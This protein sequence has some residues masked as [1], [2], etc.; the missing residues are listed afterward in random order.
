MPQNLLRQNAQGFLAFIKPLPVEGVAR[1]CSVQEINVSDP[2]PAKQADLRKLLESYADCFPDQLPCTLPPVRTVNHEIDLTPGS[3]P[4]SR[5]AFRLSQPELDELQRQISQLLHQGLIEPSKSPFG[6]PVFFVK[7]ADGSLRMVCDW[8]QLNKITIKNKACLPNIDDLFDCVQGSKYFSKL[9]LLSG[10]HQVRIREQDVPK[11]AINTAFGHY[12]FRVM[13]FGLTNAPATFQTL[14][15]EILRPFLRK[16]V[17]VFLD[18]ILIYSKDWKSHLR[19]ITSVL[20]VLRSQSL[21]CKPSKCL[22]AAKDVKF[23]GHVISGSTI[24]PDKTKIDAVSAWPR[25]VSVPDLRKFLGFAN[26]FRRFIPEYAHIARPLEQSTG[27]YAKFDWNEVKEAAFNKLKKCL[28]SAPVLHLFNPAKRTRVVTDASDYAVG[29]VLLQE[30]QPSEWHPVAYCSR[31]LTSTEQNYTTMDREVMAMIFALQMWKLYLY[32]PFEVV[33]DNQAVTYLQSKSNLSKREARWIQFLT[34]FQFTI[35][36]QPGHKNV[37]DPLSRRPDYKLNVLQTTVNLDSG[38]LQRIKKGYKKDSELQAI[39]NRLISSNS[40]DSFHERY[41]W[42]EKQSLLF[43]KEDPPRLCIPQGSVRLRLL[44]EHHDCLIAGHQGRDR[45]LAR[46]Q[47]TF[48]WPGLPRDVQRFIQSCET[49]QRCKG[50][51]VHQGLLQP[52]PVP[53]RPWNHI[54]MDFIVGLPTSVDGYD[55]IYTFVDR[56]SKYVHL[57]PTTQTVDAKGS[58]ELYVQNVFRLHGLSKSIVSDRDPRFTATFFQEIFNLLGTQL[59]FSTSNHPETDG[60]T[61]RMNRIV[62]D[63]LRCFVNHRQNN[64]STLLPLCEFAINDMV[65]GS[66]NETPFFINLG[67]HPR[68]PSDFLT[69][70]IGSTSTGEDSRLWL[71][72]RQEAISA[73]RDSMIAAQARQSRYADQSRVDTTFSVGD[74]VMVH[75]DFICTSVARDQP[76]IKLRPKWFGPYKISSIPSSTTVK[77]KLPADCRFHPVFHVSALKRYHKNMFQGRSQLPPAP[78][79]DKEGHERYIV[80]KVLSSRTRHGKTQYLVKWLGYVDPTWEPSQ[81]LMDESGLPIIPLRDFLLHSN[82]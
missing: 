65:Q 57:V 11:T 37:A 68:S 77:L 71:S 3:A 42:D 52:L 58:A 44:Q 34:D 5:P 4:P 79:T 45:T 1:V 16:S 72:S 63:V 60:Q 17:V 69:P 30:S 81:Y 40:S 12:Q 64:W 6:A 66:T 61:E 48:Y 28:L 20:D 9:D 59:K 29:G 19:D 23:L 76:C 53:D 67:Y 25:P 21:Y 47:R 39:I 73:A 41:L 46:L 55:A 24:S 31:R 14:M 36:H 26:Y 7:K 8:R 78:F 49:C 50:N 32:Q 51:R 74:Y 38:I 82:K 80:D 43:L 18:D 75:R 56:L 22:F 35:I 10:Y 2:T 54:S 13:G 33:T 15:N 27:R 62:G 70:N